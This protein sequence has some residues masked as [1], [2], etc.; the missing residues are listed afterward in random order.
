ME[1]FYLDA[2]G[3]QQGPV[4]AG[5]LLQLLAAGRIDRRR[6]V[7]RAGLEGWQPLAALAEELGLPPETPSAP[8]TPS[9]APPPG[10]V[11]DVAQAGL[12]R[13]WAALIVDNLILTLAFYGLLFL[14][15]LTVMSGLA[16][17]EIGGALA[18]LMLPLYYVCAGLY[19]A[20]QESSRHQATL[21]KRAFGIKVTDGRGQRLRLGQALGRWFAAALSYLTFYIGF[22]MAAFT[23]RRQALHD[24]VAD[25]QVTDRWAYTEH[26]ERQRH[27]P[28]PGAIVMVVLTMVVVPMLAILAAIAIPA[29]SEYTH[30]ARLAGA[31]QA[32]AP[33]QARIDKHL[34]SHKHCPGNGEAG[35]PA[36]ERASGEPAA[37]WIGRFDD[38][39][40]GLELRLRDAPFQGQ[41]IWL[42]RNAQERWI[43]ASEIDDRHLPSHCRGWP[44]EDEA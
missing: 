3:R 7:W 16:R 44:E 6:L 37:V 26:P 5:A 11:P 18:L 20:L 9:P 4:D 32:Q 35:F 8:S 30:R 22:L 1:W 17:G 36:L 33:L 14:L 41:R 34:R 12:I 29:Y 13:R 2:A 40:C 42:W 28:G 21:G 10:A 31:V 38:G 15:L 23:E 27:R 25:T 39:T 19:Y 43:C 24:L